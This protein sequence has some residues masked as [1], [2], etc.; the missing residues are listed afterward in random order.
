MTVIPLTI[1][2][3]K[4]DSLTPA[5]AS[6]ILARDDNHYKLEYFVVAGVAAVSR[7]MLAYANADW[8]D[9]QVEGWPEKNETPFGVF[10]ILYI[11]S[12]EGKKVTLA[13]GVVIDH[14]L[15]KKCDLLGDNEWE[16]QMIKIFHSSTLSLRERTFMRWTWNYKEVMD[17]AYD[18]FFNTHLPLWI[19]THAKHLKDN[20]SNGHYVGSRLSLADLITANTI[21]HFSAIPHGDEI[22]AKIRTSSPEIWKVKEAVDNE[23]RLQKWRAT[24]EYKKHQEMSQM[25]Y[26]HTGI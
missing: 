16:E 5:E 26:A 20:G 3:F 19:D 22:V 6:E 4:E 7:D 10:P 2:K 15:A 13:E 18:K 24:E 25:M 11:H 9:K 8:E 14:F 12:R 21:D 1:T 23:P 17:K